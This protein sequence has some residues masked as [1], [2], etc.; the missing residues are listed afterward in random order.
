MRGVRRVGLIVV[1]FAVMSL[2]ALAALP[3]AGRAPELSALPPR[4]REVEIGA[5]LVLNVRELGTGSPVVLV[6]GLPSN[7]GDWAGVPDA[8]AARGHRVVV[9]D[10]VGY[11]WSSRPP[12]A[13]GAYTLDSNARELGALLERLDIARAALVGWSYGGGIVQTFAQAHPDRASRLVLLGSVGPTI[14][15][16]PTD[17]IGK[18]GRSPLGPPVFRYV[19]S[20]PP[21]GRGVLEGALA[22]VFSGSAQIPPGWVD[23][24]AAQMA[25]PGTIDS[26]LAEERNDGY[27]TLRPEA[28]QAPV[29]V[30][31]GGDD[32]AVRVA[33]AED[34]AQRLPH[35]KLVVVEGGS[36]M[37]P[38]THTDLVASQVDAWMATP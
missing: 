32:R 28:I 30:L 12:V 2:A 14:G 31:H 11:G 38:V 3:L 24:S 29:L 19:T 5:G 21:L 36:H 20:V 35:G 33:V 9:Y 17:F 23:R 18:L 26:W 22:D 4:D 25:L 13:G 37:L 1:L 10:R 7:I 6:H 16:E 15:D 8:L 34:L 27:S